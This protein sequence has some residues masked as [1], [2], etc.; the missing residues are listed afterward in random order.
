[1]RSQNVSAS[2]QHIEKDLA[3][4]NIY[5]VSPNKAMKRETAAKAQY[6]NIVMQQ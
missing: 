6:Q 4:N 3:D 2:G 1:M 5:E